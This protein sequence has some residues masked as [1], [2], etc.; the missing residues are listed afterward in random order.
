MTYPLLLLLVYCALVTFASLGGGWLPTRW[1]LGHTQMQVL[2]SLVAGLMVGV[3]ILHLLPHAAIDLGSLDDAAFWMLVGLLAM[4]FMIRLFHVHQHSVADPSLQDEE[5][6]GEGHA[7]HDHA[8]H[9]H[10]HD[11]EHGPHHGHHHHGG[12]TAGWR[13]SWLGLAFGLALHSF[14]DG[15]ALGAQLMADLHLHS[16]ASMPGAG[17]FAVVLLHKPLDA[18]AITSL[19]A[20][21]G[22][23]LQSM[24]GVNLAFAVICP[25]GAVLFYWGAAGHAALVGAALGVAAGV[26]ICIALAD[27]LPE[28]SFH[29]HD[30]A[31][32]SVALLLGVLL[33]I[34]IGFLEGEGHGHG[35]SH[36]VEH[37]HSEHSHAPSAGASH[38]H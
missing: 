17:V 35:H 29:A 13:F 31:K 1:R 34:S 14:F 30:R 20:A 22:W 4:F 3:A 15:V 5:E 16:E 11:H 23:S 18:L 21:R 25:A 9:A 36:E 24:L 6:E 2:M 8:H 7:H 37:Q 10:K 27:I 33:A 38:S 32:L 28:V 12:L 26:F 19:M